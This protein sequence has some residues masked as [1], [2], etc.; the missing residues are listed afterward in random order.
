MGEGVLNR[1]VLFSTIA[2]GDDVP[3]G[4]GCSRGQ[5]WAGPGPGG[6]APR[7][8]PG[9]IPSCQWRV[10]HCKCALNLLLFARN[11][12]QALGMQRM[13]PACWRLMQMGVYFR[14]F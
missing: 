10:Y 1:K 14:M 8:L 4:L 3:P 7:L 2:S 5:C 12:E 6:S 11:E 9:L 13:F